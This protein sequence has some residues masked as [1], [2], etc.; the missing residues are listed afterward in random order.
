MIVAVRM[1][2]IVVVSVI[3]LMLMAVI[4][5]TLVVMMMFPVI[6]MVVVVAVTM[7]VVALGIRKVGNLAVYLDHELQAGNSL[8]L[9]TFRSDR[10][11]LGQTES[12]KALAYI[13]ER[14][15][16]VDQGSQKHIAG[17]A[18]GTINV[19]FSHALTLLGEHIRVGL[20]GYLHQLAQRK[21]PEGR[22]PS[23]CPRLL[24]AQVGVERP[25]ISGVVRS[26][27]LFSGLDHPFY[28]LSA[29]F[30]GFPC[31]HVLPSDLP[32]SS[33]EP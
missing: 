6:A 7:V 30:A 26:K 24:H 14:R 33:G 5:M 2:V 3:V 15:A 11:R 10:P 28:H 12:C 17:D 25:R 20:L 19:K 31:R 9:D 23:G 13:F 18:G 8:L 21:E 22:L 1:S 32:H 27:A 29:D 4:V 16:Q